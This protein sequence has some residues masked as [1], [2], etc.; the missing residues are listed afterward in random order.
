MS[1]IKSVIVKKACLGQDDSGSPMYRVNLD[2]GCFAWRGI[3][4]TPV[5]TN[6][7]AAA[8]VQKKTYGGSMQPVRRL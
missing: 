7:M 8:I 5:K 6:V 2:G 3:N 1:V 4:M